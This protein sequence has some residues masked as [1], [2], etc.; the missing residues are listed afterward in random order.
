LAPNIPKFNPLFTNPHVLTVLGNYWPRKYDWAAYPMESRL[1]RTAPTVEVLVQTQRPV[2]APRGELVLLHGLEG[3]G[4]SGYIVSLA[5]R[6]LSSGFTVHRF[7][8]RT[9]GGTELLCQT[10]YHA[11]LTT[12]LLSFVEQDE[13]PRKVFLVGFSLGGNVALKAAGETGARLLAGVVSVNTPIDLAACSRRLQ[14][15]VNRVYQDRFTSRMKERLLRTGRYSAQDLERCRSVFD[16]DD[17][18]TAP[19]FG[20]GNAANYYETQSALRF[21]P[22]I[23]VPTLMIAAQDDPLVPYESYSD[24]SLA[25]NPYIQ[26]LSPAHG[27]H[28]G[29]LSRRPP[30]FWADEVIMGWLERHAC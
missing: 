19:S 27:G 29:F 18:I 10:L 16:I 1:V 28:L 22:Y 5:H 20:F 23:Q 9:C 6:A 3:S 25:A 17:K 15:P 14:M 8:M 21:V 13:H 11:G 26:L 12:D 2:G 4:E 24:P 30:R 7:H